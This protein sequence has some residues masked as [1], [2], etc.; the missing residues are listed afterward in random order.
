MSR[1][2]SWEAIERASGLTRAQVEDAAD[3]YAK[4]KNVIV[5]YGMGITQHVHGTE[6]VQQIANLLLLRGNDR[7][8]R[9]GNLPAAR[10]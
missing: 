1:T 9:G 4:A 5:C 7:P 8:P 10:P 2:P 3:I 6:N